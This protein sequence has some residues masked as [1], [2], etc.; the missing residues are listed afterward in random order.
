MRYLRDFLSISK[1]RNIFPHEH[2]LFAKE[3]F[4]W[5]KGVKE[6]MFW[7]GNV[8]EQKLPYLIGHFHF[9]FLFFEFSDKTLTETRNFKQNEG[10]SE[11]TPDK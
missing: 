1:T 7:G 6:G 9:C 3:L 10:L 4:L 2:L 8:Y 5:E 11:H